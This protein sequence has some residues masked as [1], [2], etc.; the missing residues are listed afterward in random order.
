[1]F[2]VCGFQGGREH[3]VP[4]LISEIDPDGDTTGLYVGD[5]VLSVN[6][7]DLSQVNSG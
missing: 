2:T 6:C 5:S 7:V 4:I 1:M 3:G